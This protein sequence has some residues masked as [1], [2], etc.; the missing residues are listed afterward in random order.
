L[1]HLRERKGYSQNRLAKESGVAQ[2]I[3]QRLE[4]GARGVDHLSVGVARKLAKTL[5]V[6]VDHLIGMYEDE[7]LPR[8]PALV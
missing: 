3:V 7:R 4:A 6:S 5:G 8:E 1:R 2:A